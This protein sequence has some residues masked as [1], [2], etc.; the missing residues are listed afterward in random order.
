MS[1]TLDPQLQ[2]MAREAFQLG[3]L[4]L[5]AAHQGDRSACESARQHFLIVLEVATPDAW[6]EMW[7]EARAG[8]N[9]ARWLADNA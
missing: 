3:L 1:P 9:E 5:I 8:L 6:P 2:L 7:L 4:D